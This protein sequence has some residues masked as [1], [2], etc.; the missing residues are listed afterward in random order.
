MY[1]LRAPLLSAVARLLVVS[2]PVE[3][4]DLIYVMGGN[5]AARPAAAVQLYRAGYARRIAVPR[6]EP[7]DSVLEGLRLHSTIE[8]THILQR[9][10]VP[11]SAIVI[12]EWPGGSTSTLD[13]ARI[14]VSYA[15]QAGLRR[16]IVVTSELHTRRT[17]WA[18]RKMMRRDEPFQLMVSPAIE[19]G[20]RADN[21]WKSEDGLLQC[22]SEY[23]KFLHNLIYS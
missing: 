8:V 23:L 11:R 13:D 3:P 16:V 2:D 15:R 17:R 9:L 21:W 6:V 22:A 7:L 18:L 10:G 20:V 5:P 12:L 14:L 1:F 19:A 4:A